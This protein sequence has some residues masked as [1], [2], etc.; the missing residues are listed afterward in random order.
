MRLLFRSAI[1]GTWPHFI[2]DIFFF[3]LK[4]ELWMY[5]KKYQI[6]VSIFIIN[7][8]RLFMSQALVIESIFVLGL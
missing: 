8:F 6:V 1:S 4:H 7:V 3:V 2:C 5:V